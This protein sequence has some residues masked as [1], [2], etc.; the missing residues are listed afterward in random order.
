MSQ[1]VRPE[2]MTLLEAA[3]LHGLRGF[4]GPIAIGLR[5]GHVNG[6]NLTL[7]V[8]VEVLLEASDPLRPRLHFLDGAVTI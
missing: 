5:S 4:A 7:P 1:C 2:E 3:L 8:G 6:P